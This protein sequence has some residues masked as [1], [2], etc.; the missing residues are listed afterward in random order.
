MMRDAA[1]AGNWNRVGLA[2]LCAISATDALLVA[3]AGRR[4]SSLAHGD[5]ADLLLAHVHDPR[6]A[7]QAT[8]LRQI[9][10]E[11]TLIEHVD[12]FFHQDDALSLQKRVERYSGW[13]QSLL[14]L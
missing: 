5:A 1:A 7:E 9:L 11:K 6:T 13:A 14:N 10:H 3:K 2:G 4:S 8:R 12:K